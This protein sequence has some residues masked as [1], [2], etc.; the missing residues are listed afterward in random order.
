[1]TL[2]ETSKLLYVITQLYT[3]HYKNITSES[4]TAQAKVWTAVLSGVEYKD[5]EIALKLYALNDGGFPP[6]PGQIV[7]KVKE[8]KRKRELAQMLVDIGQ[9]NSIEFNC[10]EDFVKVCGIPRITG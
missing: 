7:E 9:E 5:A 6:T 3:V 1:M 2:Q 8:V 4:L 10:G